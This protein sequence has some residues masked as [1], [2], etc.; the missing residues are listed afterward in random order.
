MKIKVAHIGSYFELENDIV[1]QMLR[2]LK[3][4][5]ELA[6]SEHDLGMYGNLWFIKYK[7]G[8]RGTLLIRNFFLN[9]I[10]RSNP[11]ILVLNAGKQSLTRRQFE[12]LN[13]KG[14]KI[15]GIGLSDPDLMDVGLQI[16]KYCHYYFTNS[17]IA[18]NFY[19]TSGQNNCFLLKFGT[20]IVGDPPS[21]EGKL[22]DVVIVGGMRADRVPIVNLLTESGITVGCFGRSWETS[23]VPK[24]KISES[25]RGVE[26][27]EAIRS[28]NIYFSFAGTAAG[29]ENVKIGLLDA[30]AQGACVITHDFEDVANFL[31]PGSEILTYRET[32]EIVGLILD[33][34]K[35][36]SKVLSIGKRAQER[37]LEEHLWMHRW[38]L[39]FSIIG[40]KLRGNSTINES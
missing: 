18:L 15:V 38:D 1:K 36:P 9:L 33:T 7:R 5:S 28:G 23:L 3:G 16:A 19:R 14:I 32:S 29:Y 21:I 27:L 30:A 40:V 11:D 35:S 6:V 17:S 24:A 34:L 12:R 8:P 37:V 39:V 31:N 13:K 2:A 25:V 10:I 4:Y 26:Y 20:E 22:F